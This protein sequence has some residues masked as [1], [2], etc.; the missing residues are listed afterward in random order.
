MPA[1]VEHIRC[2]V[3]TIQLAMQ[4]GLKKASSPMAKYRAVCVEAE[5]PREAEAESQKGVGAGQR[6]KV[7]HTV[8]NAGPDD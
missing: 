2:G 3:H 4:D 1:E 6:Y 8:P 5:N 7:G